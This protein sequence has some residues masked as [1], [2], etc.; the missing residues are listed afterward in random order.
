MEGRLGSIPTL[1]SH[2]LTAT[3]FNR[4]AGSVRPPLLGFGTDTQNPA[5]PA[6]FFLL[7]GC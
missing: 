5:Q 2:I 6:Q 4:A 7:G 1:Y 3:V